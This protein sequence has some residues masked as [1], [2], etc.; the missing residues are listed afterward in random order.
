MKISGNDFHTPDSDS[1]V[2]AHDRDSVTFEVEENEFA[3]IKRHE[4]KVAAE[5][6]QLSM[7]N[8][9]EVGDNYEGY[10]KDTTYFLNGGM[11]S[12]IDARASLAVLKP[13]TSG[14]TIDSFVRHT[15]KVEMREGGG[16]DRNVYFKIVA[17]GK[18][19]KVTDANGVTTTNTS[20]VVVNTDDFTPN[21]KKPEPQ[22]FPWALVLSLIAVG[23]FAA[24]V[25]RYFIAGKVVFGQQMPGPFIKGKLGQ[26][27]GAAAVTPAAPAPAP[28]GG[29]AK[30]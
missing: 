27:P 29:G 13:E 21:N 7:F 11:Q 8:Y 1:V 5:R 4:T 12:D 28:V 20:P 3:I 17:V 14:I 19:E 9:A 23:I 10:P 2:L 22:P 6:M 16:W 25:W 24:I 18:A 15:L 30:V 26:A